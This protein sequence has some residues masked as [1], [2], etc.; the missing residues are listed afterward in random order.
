M[1]GTEFEVVLILGVAS[2]GL[3][4]YPSVSVVSF[5]LLLLLLCLL[6]LL[7]PFFRARILSSLSQHTYL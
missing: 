6:L 3:L 5:I 4:L 1:V 2:D 7:L